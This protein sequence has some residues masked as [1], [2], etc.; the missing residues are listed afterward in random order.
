MRIRQSCLPVRGISNLLV[1]EKLKIKGEYLIKQQQQGSLISTRLPQYS[2]RL[3]RYQIWR[4]FR[5]V[6]CFCTS[7]SRDTKTG[8]K[9]SEKKTCILQFTFTDGNNSLS[10]SL[11]TSAGW[12]QQRKMGIRGWHFQTWMSYLIEALSLSFMKSFCPPHFYETLN[13]SKIW[14]HF[15][16]FFL[17]H[18]GK[19]YNVPQ[20]LTSSPFVRCKPSLTVAFLLWSGITQHSYWYH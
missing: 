6:Q 15:Y 18:F 13:H 16:S 12:T 4:A 11:A 8:T 7:A 3:T 20:P 17:L 14:K 1:A 5:P 9:V 19:S 2:Y 10:E